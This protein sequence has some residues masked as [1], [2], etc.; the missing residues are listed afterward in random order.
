MH[1]FNT[2]HRWLVLLLGLLFASPCGWAQGQAARGVSPSVS[3]LIEDPSAPVND[4]L[5]ALAAE[6]EMVIVATALASEGDIA[7]AWRILSSDVKDA[8]QLEGVSA[9]RLGWRAATVAAFLANQENHDAAIRFAKL[10]LKQDWTR[11]SEHNDEVAYWSAK[12]ASEILSDRKQALRFIGAGKAHEP[13]RMKE[14]RETLKAAE[15]A[16][17]GR[18]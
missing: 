12:I 18:G 1:S 9:D 17:D 7:G 14:L 16:F 3:K 15:K 5:A 10:A 11:A 4:V 6:R 13:A 2:K 8:R